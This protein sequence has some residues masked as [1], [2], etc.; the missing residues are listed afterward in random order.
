MDRRTQFIANSIVF[1]LLFLT[2]FITFGQ[3]TDSIKVVQTDSCSRVSM[4][5]KT[6]TEFY[7]AKRNL[8]IL[9]KEIPYIKNKLD[10]LHKKNDEISENY[11]AELDAL[12][13]KA[14]VLNLSLKD[15]EKTAV[16]MQLENIKLT[17]RVNCL[18]RSRKVY[19]GVGIGIGVIGT[20]GL[21]KAFSQ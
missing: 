6:F 2:S 18:I 13:T 17:N 1:I 21:I 10:S 19:F 8:E 4:S 7:V 12:N 11:K 14:K 20:F 9:S 3:C 16:E 15:C 5:V